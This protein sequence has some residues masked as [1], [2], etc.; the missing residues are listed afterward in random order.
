MADSPAAAYVAEAYAGLTPAAQ[1]VAEAYGALAPNAFGITRLQRILAKADVSVGGKRIGESHIRQAN[2]AI[3][4][5]GLAGHHSN[6][7]M[8]AA[9]AHAFGLARLAHEGGRLAAICDSYRQTQPRYHYDPHD[10]EIRLRC[11]LIAGAWQEV[12]D[13][14]LHNERFNWTILADRE[15]Q[16]IIPGLPKR[17]LANAL[18]DCLEHVIVT[19]ADPEPIIDS[20]GALSPEPERHAA[21]VSFARVLQGRFDDAAAVFDALPEEAAASR[22]AVAGRAATLA[23]I[24]FLQGDDA[25]ARRRIDETLALERAGTRKR[26]VF[27]DTFQFTLSLL[28]LVRIDSPDST[29]QLQQIVRAAERTRMTHPAELDLVTMAADSRS[30]RGVYGRLPP[31]PW[32][33]A[34]YDGLL[35]CWLRDFHPAP[36]ARWEALR[37]YRARA[38]Q[39]SYAW[40]VAECDMVLG[41][42]EQ[43]HGERGPAPAAV[44][45]EAL[46]TRSLIDLAV[47]PPEWE[48]SLKALEQ[49]AH[50][51]NQHAPGKAKGNAPAKRRLAWE[52]ELTHYA[53]LDAREQRQNKNGSWTKGRRVALRRLVSEAV[54]M[55]FLLP[56][57]RE[58]ISAI[59][60]YRGWS[61]VEYR[62]GM[63][64]VYALAGHPNVFNARGEAVDIV[65]REPEL[66]I[67]EDAAGNAVVRIEP[68]SDDDGDYHAAMAGDR[69]CEVTRFSAEHHRL[70]DAV[71]AEGLNMPAAAK[72]R[73]L[74]AV[75]GLAGNIRVQSATADGAENARAVA[76]DAEPWVRMEPFEAGLAVALVVEPIAD[77]DICFEPGRGGAVVFAN[78]QG[79]NVQAKRD[80]DAEQQAAN[81]LVQ[82]CPQL[83]MRPTERAPLTLPEP[84]DCLEFLDALRQAEARC[85][86]PK[87]EPLRI[88]AQA[89]APSLQL[90]VKSAAEWMQASGKLTVDEERVLDLKRLFALLDAR[91]GSRFLELESGEFL[92]LSGTF[93][94]QLDDFASFSSAAAEG[95]MRLH[96]LAALALDDLMADAALETDRTWRDW[97]K[98]LEAAQAVEPEL[99]STLQG[100]L[101]PYQIE[102][103][104]WLAR[105]AEWNAG[106]CLADDMGLG[107]TIQTLAVLLR[108][109]PN[110]PALVVAPTSVVANWV[111]EAHRF[112]PT[113][114]V[115]VYTGMVASRAALL[116]APAAF[117]LVVTTYGL[118]QNDI[119]RLAQI[120]WHSVVL[121]E[122]QAIKNPNA[123]RSRAARRLQGDF[124]IVTTG[125][126]VQNNLMDLHSLFGFLNPGLLG[127]VQRFRS[128]FG[129]PIERD[130]DPVAQARLQ[131]LIAPFVLRRLKTDVLKDLP[132]R[133]EITLHVEM[134]EEESALYEA[135][136]QRA[137]EELE[138]ARQRGTEVGEGARRVQVL[139]QLTKL[140]LA[141]CNPRLVLEQGAPASSK[142]KTFAR[143]LGDLLEN[144]HKVLVF[145][146]F[147]MH[148]KLIE[149]YLKGAAVSYQYLDGS[150]PAK[151]RAERIAAFQ[152][153]EGDVFLISLKAGGVGLNLT[154]AD[155][156]IH[157]DPWWNPAVE[158]QASDRA[159][160]IGQ[161][162]PVTI[163]RLVSEGTIEE[164]IVDLHHR[165][166]Y[167]ADQ[168]LEGTDAAGRLDADELLELLRQPLTA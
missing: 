110:G 128:E 32:L 30:G 39:S 46:G 115:T 151:A 120:A 165:K 97:R 88:V 21:M 162:R 147:V 83:A 93:R 125:T 155:Y 52:L 109:A 34:L 16:Y 31:E 166:R 67:D 126:P 105:L 103:F 124:R 24:A 3:A 50:R 129:V 127:S 63:A 27:S 51:A 98:R 91:P 12:D 17:H 85:K 18:S 9:P 140:R 111:D 112:A 144:R 161:T 53:A 135:L 20:C 56:Q 22:A 160:R 59:K 65:R 159:H 104:Q 15:A 164:Q 79:E 119:D 66:V 70:F 132:E 145:S 150:T 92:A 114:N 55:D 73:L 149:E 81:R 82:R 167:L 95:A 13:L 37:R 36:V 80:L 152:A 5:A 99:P 141:C 143:T 121:D 163:Y 157:M 72:P 68:Y 28:A 134:S 6:E 122:A 86:W 77:S 69:R 118:L 107:K 102:G 96:P 139:A 123:K 49:I 61:G 156:V 62:L 71:P 138:S 58:A 54:N 117:D 41:C 74:S 33:D 84:L 133:T 101:R 94:R 100:E 106:A 8:R 11:S 113:L 137:V 45:H 48:S 23:L 76:A 146:Q 4:K 42:F 47:P 168:L 78:V 14:L 154:A 90:T 19:G 75:A 87:G 108:R 64:G 153:G 89:S 7:G 35:S 136:R 130:A 44:G 142:L 158:D 57:D 1:R 60:S 29:E 131:R 38:L 148:L 116:E 2:K 10:D 26:L 25:E 40:I 43:L